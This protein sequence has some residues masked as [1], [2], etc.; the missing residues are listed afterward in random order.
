MFV[1][2]YH[3]L[4]SLLP[5]LDMGVP[6]EIPSWEFNAL[7]KQNLSDGDKELV[8]VIRRHIDI[9]NLRP[10]WQGKE[11]DP[12]GNYD[13]KEL[14]EHLMLEEGFPDY[15]FEFL[16]EHESIPERIKF[17]PVLLSRFFLEEIEN[18]DHF[19]KDY[20]IFEREWRLVMLAIR[21]K[22]YK[23]DLGWELQHEDPKEELVA[24]ILA[25]KDAEN[26]SPPEGYE[27]LETIFAEFQDEPLKLHWELNS[28]RLKKIKDIPQRGTFSID[29][30]LSYLAQLILVE[31]WMKLS[32]EEGISVVENI[33]KEQ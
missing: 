32:H 28:W 17:F 24:Q 12:H 25:Q 13:A 11:L 6:P 3:F 23:R 26:F 5:S 27:E 22:L 30:I 7:C 4:A 21:C 29:R 16:R 10:F 1:K 8:E 15:V 20:L 9:K 19:L 2:N 31:N 33:M 14:E 18:A